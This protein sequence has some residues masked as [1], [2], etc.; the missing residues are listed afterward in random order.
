MKIGIL[1]TDTVRP[2]W[3]PE[4]GEY[5]DMFKR[6]LGEAD[7]DLEFVVWDVEAGELPAHTD[8]A[9]GYLI[10]GS[11]SSV[12]EDKPWIRALEAFV[13]TLHAEKRKV[14]GICFGH[15]LIAQAL[16]GFVEKSSKG[17]G[18]GVHTYAVTAPDL[19]SDHQGEQL[20]LLVSHQD[21]VAEMP[22][23]AVE[24]VQN[25]HCDI[26]GMRIGKHVL[27]FQGHPEFVPEYAR[28]IMEYRR[29]VIGESRVEEGLAS[30]ATE[31]QGSRVARWI[32]DFFKA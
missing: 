5:P 7:P 21:Q 6:L 27:T 2:E 3:A 23:G 24:I 22:P 4:F 8:E 1:R 31:H 17:W 16:G 19:L 26:G 15:Q 28:E 32:V 25:D 14:V 29:E 11:K 10:T 20:R 9:D 13:R 30:L 12:Y 18:V